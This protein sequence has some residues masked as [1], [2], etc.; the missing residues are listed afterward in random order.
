M[1]FSSLKQKVQELSSRPAAKKS[2][3]VTEPKPKVIIEQVPTADVVG[4]QQTVATVRYVILYNNITL[5]IDIMPTD[6]SLTLAPPEKDDFFI[7]RLIPY[8]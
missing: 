2:P 4:L 7:L 3:P 6:P 8:V 1:Y 5:S